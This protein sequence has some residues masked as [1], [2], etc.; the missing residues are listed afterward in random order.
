MK[1][2]EADMACESTDN[3]DF[4]FEVE[5]ELQK[6]KSLADMIQSHYMA[7]T[8]PEDLKRWEQEREILWAC[9][10]ILDDYI[11]KTMEMVK[12]KQAGNWI[13]S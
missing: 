12:S 4:L 1:N 10:D 6:A 7:S 9:I 2:Q 13:E 11:D 5:V 3:E 8:A